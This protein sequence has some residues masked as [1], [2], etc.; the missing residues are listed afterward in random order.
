VPD[1]LNMDTDDTAWELPGDTEAVEKVAPDGDEQ[2]PFD[3][4]E[5]TVAESAGGAGCCDGGAAAEPRRDVRESNT[6]RGARRA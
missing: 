4:G 1:W 5:E 2:Q 3:I 6:R